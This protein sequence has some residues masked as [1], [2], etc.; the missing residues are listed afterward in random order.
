MDHAYVL[1]ERRQTNNGVLRRA[2]IE[3]LDGRLQRGEVLDVVFR[4]IG[5]VCQAQLLR[6]PSAQLCRL[7][8][9]A[10][11]QHLATVPALQLLRDGIELRHA[12][13]PDDKLPHRPNVPITGGI[14]MFAAMQHMVHLR[15]R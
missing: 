1:H 2:I 11:A 7:A 12:V 3:G 9:V 10:D 5:C 8:D 13:P 4:L 14:L 6:F 15:T